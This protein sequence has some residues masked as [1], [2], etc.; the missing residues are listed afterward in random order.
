VC[1]RGG[2]EDFRSCLERSCAGVHGGLHTTGEIL[3][4]I[5]EVRTTTDVGVEM[6]PLND[7]DPWFRDG[8]EIVHPSGRFFRVIGVDVRADG[9]EV[10]SWMQPMIE[11][12]GTGLV[13]FL[14]KRVDGVLHVLVHAR[15]EP[16]YLDVVELAP[17]V[18]CTPE[19]YGVL[20]P[21]ARP[22]FLDEVLRAS[23]GAIRFEAVLAEEGGR[24]YRAR[25]RYVVVETDLD[26]SPE[27]FP[28]HRWMTMSQITGLL[29]HSH[30]VNIQARSLV[31]CLHSLLGRTETR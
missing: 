5:T 8:G 11:P 10:G 1:R 2:G 29:R 24:F 18:Q 13:A 17:T 3:N 30:Y 15:V 21:A 7:L 12:I 23:P 22:E 14:V 16:G 25:N 6:I 4:W 28:R 9:R 26:V 19:N 27:A 31:A 20:P